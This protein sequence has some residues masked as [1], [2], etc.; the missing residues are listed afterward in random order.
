MNAPDIRQ[1]NRNRNAL[2]LLVVIFFGGLLVAGAL[3]FSGWQPAGHKNHGEL[4]Q[5]AIDLRALTPRL[6]DGGEY[7][8]KPVER[9]WR[10]LVAPPSG[11]TDACVALSKQLDTVWQLFGRN[12]DQVDILWLGP[13]PEGATRN[14]A[15]RVLR[16]DSALRAR[17]PRW[18]VT[19]PAQG[20]PVYV[21]DPNGFVILRYP[22]GADPG[23]LRADVAKLLKLM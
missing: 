9:R 7:Q 8:W 3:R 2:V 23:G 22:P 12:A 16:D 15:T 19:D 14:A 13:P 6:A 18:N 10:I 20:I 5:P 1:R 4:L 17:L 11:C 21:I